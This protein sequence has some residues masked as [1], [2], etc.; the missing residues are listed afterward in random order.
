ML[1]TKKSK[2]AF[3]LV[4]YF[5]GFNFCNQVK[6][7]SREI[8]DAIKQVEAQKGSIWVTM[9]EKSLDVARENGIKQIKQKIL[10]KFQILDPMPTSMEDEI[11]TQ[12]LRKRMLSL[13][14]NA[15]EFTWESW[16]TEYLY[17]YVT[18]YDAKSYA[19]QRATVNY[20]KPLEYSFGDGFAATEADAIAAARGNLIT[21][22]SA[23]ITSETN[24][25]TSEKTLD[26]N[27]KGVSV[28]TESEL[29]VEENNGKYDEKFNSK[30]NVIELD[31]SISGTVFKEELV[32]KNR[33]YSQ[34]TLL[35]LQT[36]T[37]NLGDEFYAFVYISAPDKEKSFEAVKSKITTATS[38]ME[39]AFA[40][41]NI[42]SG[43]KGLY[44][45]YILSDTYYTA[46]PYEFADGVKTENLQESL[47][48]RIDVLL[49]DEV[50]V[51]AR[52]A[53]LVDEKDLVAP[54]QILYKGKALDGL[55][56]RFKF[57]TYSFSGSLK[58]G[59]GRLKL[60]NYTPELLSEA[61][62]ISLYI[63]I[64]DDINSDQTIKELESVKRLVIN[65]AIKVDFTNV[66]K[67]GVEGEFYGN[68]VDFKLSQIKPALVR[69]THWI[70]GDGEERFTSEPNLNYTYD[71]PGQYEI[72]VEINGE[73]SLSIKRFVDTRSKRIR[74]REGAKEIV[75]EIKEQ[76][77]EEKQTS[78]I[79]N[80]SVKN[81]N[82]SAVSIT[83]NAAYKE[84]VD[85][86]T[87]QGLMAYLS[88]KKQQG[89]LNFGKQADFV[90]SEGALIIVADPEKVHER[91]IFS[92]N[93]FYKVN[94]GTE[95]VSL[96][97]SYRGKY[98]IW[99]KKN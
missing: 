95:V 81:D 79:A 46:V 20:R 71:E 45:S 53:Y 13:P 12:M 8:K 76:T 92:N 38:E 87:T 40:N 51:I 70:L 80:M 75:A 35:G 60:P 24:L 50:E 4:I 84:I 43:L 77:A 6:A 74:V 41:G 19:V 22:F 59:K 34:M 44:K 28:R 65:R 67:F 55:L 37:L 14:I 48:S 1:H 29:K 68:R 3:T 31:E 91:L 88:A 9:S 32:V 78:A 73:P 61:F 72:T 21:Q 96:A 89:V 42:V 15:K 5:L 52:P 26:V 54:F 82:P 39:R 94:A 23:K 97:D 69:E 16:G 85:L 27:Q 56:Y 57:Q 36:L 10:N 2:L 83:L 90:D 30:N 7:Q 47:R 18:D 93:R 86:Q 64:S 11:E 58:G 99:I 63:D 66:F 62:N 49:K 33:V 98:L 25:T 17:I